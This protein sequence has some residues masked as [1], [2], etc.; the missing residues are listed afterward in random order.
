MVL[1]ARCCSLLN[2]I[3]NQVNCH[4]NT[5]GADKVADEGV[6]FFALQEASEVA[7]APGAECHDD[8][9]GPVDFPGDAKG[10]GAE[11]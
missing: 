3:H 6:A 8:G 9:D 5:C 1:L 2:Q 4:G 7:A 10:Y 11:D